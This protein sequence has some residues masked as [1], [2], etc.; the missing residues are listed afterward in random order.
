MT[1]E[2]QSEQTPSAERI[3]LS[4]DEGFDLAV[5]LHRSGCPDSAEM[6]YR[7]ILEALPTHL[8]SLNFLA[9]LCHQQQ[10]REEAADLLGRIISVDPDNPDAHNNLGNVLDGMG[11]KRDAEARFRKAIEIQPEHAPALNNLGVVLTSRGALDEAL[12]VYQRAV[13]GD[14]ENADYRYN[15]GNALRKN[16]RM[17]AAL[18][19]YGK[20]VELDSAHMGAWQG[21]TRALIQ[22]GREEAALAAFD[23]WIEK[24]PQN[25]V[26]RYLQA[27]CQGQGAPDRAPDLFVQKTF[28]EMAATFDDHLQNDLDYR[29][30][31]LIVEALAEHLPPT[32]AALDI[33]DAGCGTGLCGPLL[34]P[35]SRHLAGVDLSAGMLTRARGTTYYDELVQAE[36]TE[37]LKLRP[38]AYDL[39]VSA[40]TLCYFGDL[41]TVL[42]WAARGLR[43]GGRMAFTLEAAETDA[44]TWQLSRNGRYV[45]HPTYI[46]NVAGD[47]GFDATV[48]RPVILRTEGGEPVRGLLVLLTT[49]RAHG[50]SHPL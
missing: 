18:A 35:F 47:A 26:A 39:I 22:T 9:L 50:R 28:D 3:S 1:H 20:A 4:V 45:H 7:R 12:D 46:K 5:Q 21:L 8:N 38:A 25:P 42:T 33:L 19:A 23:A 14:P 40:D 27:A 32:G 37:F 17:D 36:I 10:R 41:R 48:I 13:E 15:M 29:A 2:T 16:G 30:P 44:V 24:D 6:L 43:P 31:Q 34:K 49:R 11:R